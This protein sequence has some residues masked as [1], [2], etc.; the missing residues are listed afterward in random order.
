MIANIYKPVQWTSFDVVK[1]IRNISKE[2]KVG[3]AGTLD[4]FAEGVLVIGTGKDTKSLTEISGTDKTY[5]AVL[6]LGSATDTM[7]IEGTTTDLCPIPEITENK[8][9]QVF[10]KF[11]GNLEQIPPM[12]SAK[13][14]NGIRLYKLA[15][16]NQVVH[17]EPVSIVIHKLQFIFYENPILKFSVHCSKGTYV[18]VLGN[19][20]AKELETVGHLI[21][22]IRTSVGKFTI[23]ESQTIDEFSNTWSSITN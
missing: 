13:K 3:H 1:K 11:I 17:R 5:E 8:I 12:Y 20:I 21:Q 6:K 9:N 16:K 2:K 10:S 18:R 15:R 14:V 7:D 19:D 23:N 22:L 4:P